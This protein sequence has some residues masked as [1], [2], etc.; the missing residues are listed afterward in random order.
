[1]QLVLKQLVSAGFIFK[2]KKSTF[3]VLNVKDLGYEIYGGCL[4]PSNKEAR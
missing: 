4:E 3:M 1:M 2:L